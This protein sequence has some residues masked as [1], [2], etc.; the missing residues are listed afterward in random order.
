MIEKRL[1]MKLDS[2]ELVLL[3]Q[4]LRPFETSFGVETER[5]IP[6][7]T[8]RSGGLEGYAE[9]VMDPL[10]LFR[11]ETLAGALDLVRETFLPLLLGRILRHPREIN[12]L[13]APFRGNRMAKALVE[14]AAWDLW[15][16]QQGQPLTRSCWAACGSAIP[17]GVSLGIQ[18]SIE[19]TLEL[20]QK[21]LDQGY[22]RIKLKIKPG[23]DVNLIAPVREAFPEIDLTVDANSAYS[24]EDLPAPAA[25]WMLSTWITS[26]SP[27]LTTTSSTTPG[28]RPS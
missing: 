21:H 13:L 5:T 8:L 23:W 12:A 25:S 4:L 10:P 6:I 18:P 15:A 2:A 27:W 26:S 3:L 19:A 9:G 7:L 22:Q 24:L 11:E 1:N 17:V 14:M 16:R 20:I 28:C